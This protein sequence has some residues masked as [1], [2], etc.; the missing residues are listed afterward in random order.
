MKRRDRLVL[1]LAGR[2]PDRLL[3]ES[4]RLFLAAAAMLIGVDSAFLGA[5]TSGLGK[6]APGLVNVEF[7]VLF[8]VG[9]VASLIGL[10]WNKTWLE[11]LGAALIGVGALLFVYG[12]LVYVGPGGIPAAVTYVGFAVTYGLR[13][14]C[15]ARKRVHLRHPEIDRHG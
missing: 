8:L 9:G 13:L 11:A 12:V 4:E 5:P 3:T 7:G 10:W 14:L 1:W 15:I 6:F 2:L